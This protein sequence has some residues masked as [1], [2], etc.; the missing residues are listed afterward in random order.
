VNVLAN[1][2][3]QYLTV[4]H[5]TVR[6]RDAGTGPALLLVH[7][8]AGYLEEWEPAMEILQEK[9]RVITL[10]LPG[11]GLSDKP[12]IAYTID[13]LAGFLKSFLSTMKLDKVF[14]AGH[15]LGGAISLSFT[16][17]NP[18][19]VERLILINS[20]FTR[21]P[22][23]IRLGSFG[24]LPAMFRKIPFAFVKA[25]GRQTFYI[26]NQIP[27]KWL[28]DS[29]R[30]INEPGVLRA[31]FSIIRS[32]MTLA[33]LKKELS[34]ALLK[35]IDQLAVPTLILYGEND[36]IVPN[37]NSKLLHQSLPV[38]E[39]ISIKN[40]GHELQF[41]CCDLFCRYAEDFLLS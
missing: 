23:A 39:C 29:Y 41:E 19:L 6:F 7:G 11:H 3:D 34:D 13:Y 1:S 35:K 33:G 37:I 31:M 32:N 21:I 28:E 30:Y 9:F 10:D 8:I 12:D 2:T 15:S 40:C 4:D 25:T 24:F 22:L 17:Q 16:L 38:S 5:C 20:A 18:H 26:Q 14:L 36:R 27:S